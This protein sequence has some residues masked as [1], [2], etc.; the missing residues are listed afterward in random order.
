MLMLSSLAFA[1][2]LLAPAT[3]ARKV[4][5]SYVSPPTPAVGTIFHVQPGQTIT[6]DIVAQESDPNSVIGL[7]D[8]LLPPGATLNPDPPL[9]VF[10]NGVDLPTITTTFSWTPDATQVGNWDVLFDSANLAGDRNFLPIGIIVEKPLTG[11]TYTQGGWGAKPAGNN[12]GQLLKTRFASVYASFVE[13]GIPGAG[14]FSLKF[15]SAAAIEKFLPAK[16]GPKKLTADATNPTTSAAGEFAGQVLSLQLSVDFGN[17]GATDEGPIGG[18]VL[19]NTGNANL[20]GLTI[21]QVLADANKVLGGGALPAWATSVSGVNDVVTD[22][23][24]AFDDCITTQWALD[25]LS[26]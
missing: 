1:A 26:N 12:P 13:I 2:S 20:D 15:T 3:E 19:K 25:H 5:L 21:A 4:S 14:G 8:L 18:F 22:L 16:G 6:F 11:C 9:A 17:A 7:V 23:N 24:E 10:G